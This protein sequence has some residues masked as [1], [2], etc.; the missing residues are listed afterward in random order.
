MIGEVL[1][2]VRSLRDASGRV[3]VPMWLIPVAAILVAIAVVLV[4][5]VDFAALFR[6]WQKSATPAPPNE[7]PPIPMPKGGAPLDQKPQEP[8]P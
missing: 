3:V 5:H 4:R 1:G 7:A 2:V 8:Q 6:A